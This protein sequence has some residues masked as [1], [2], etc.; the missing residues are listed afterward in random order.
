MNIA[1]LDGVNSVQSTAQAQMRAMMSRGYSEQV[2]NSID[3]ISAGY[4]FANIKG[5]GGIEDQEAIY[6]YLVRIKSVVEASPSVAYGYQDPKQLLK[7]LQF[8]INNWDTANR[9]NAIEQMAQEEERL[10]A[11]GAISVETDKELFTPSDD[12]NFDKDELIKKNGQYYRN[13]LKRGFFNQLKKITGGAVLAPV[14]RKAVAA[15]PYFAKDKQRLRQAVAKARKMTV[16]LTPEGGV[17]A[18]TRIAPN[19]LFGLNGVDDDIEK[20]LTGYDLQNFGATGSK[21]QDLEALRQYYKRQYRILSARPAEYFEN[22][23][24]RDTE[25]AK[26]EYMLTNLNDVSRLNQVAGLLAGEGM[27]EADY[28]ELEETLRDSRRQRMTRDFYHR[29]G[30]LASGENV[31]KRLITSVQPYVLSREQNLGATKLSVSNFNYAAIAKGTDLDVSTLSGIGN[32]NAV[33]NYLGRIITEINENPDEYFDYQTDYDNAIGALMYAYSN[34]GNREVYRNLAGVGMS[35]REY[36][37]FLDALGALGAKKTKEQKAEEKAAKKIAKAEKKAAKKQAKAEKKIEKQ[38]E[39][40]AKKIAK[41]EAK[42]EKKQAKAEKKIEKLQQKAANAKNEKQTAK[43]QTKIQNQQDKITAAQAKKDEKIQTIKENTADNIAWQQDK[44]ATAQKD[45]DRKINRANEVKD[46][47]IRKANAT[48]KEEKK[49]IQKEAKQKYYAYQKEVAKATGE[50]IKKTFKRVVKY[51]KKV[52]KLIIKYNPICLLIRGGLLMCLSLNL[53]RLAAKLYPGTLTQVEAAKLGVDAEMYT[54][55]VKGWQNAVKIYTNLGGTEPTLKLY[56]QKGANKHW[57]GDD[58]YS[59]LRLTEAAT[60]NQAVLTDLVDKE[61]AALKK[62]GATPTDDPNVTYHVSKQTVE[63]ETTANDPN[64]YKKEVEIEVEEPTSPTAVATNKIA[65][66]A[67]KAA[68]SATASKLITAVNNKVITTPKVT[69][70]AAK[71]TTTPKVTTAVNKVTTTPKVTTAAAKVT[72]TPKVTT[73]AAKVTTTPKVTTAVNKVTTTPKV[74]TAVNK[75][76]TTPKVTTTAAKVTTTP[77]VTTA[78]NKVTTTPKV[79]TAAAKVTTTPK[80]TT[81]V[82]KVTTTPKVTTTAAK[83]TTTPKVTTAVNKVT[84]TPKVTTT[85]AK[86]TTTPKVTTKAK[87][88]VSVVKRALKGL[89]VNGYLNGGLGEPVTIAASVTAAGTV[90]AAIIAF[91]N[92]IGVNGAWLKKAGKKVEDFVEKKQFE[93]NMTEEEKAVYED[94]SKEEKKAYREMTD[95]ERERFNVV[96]EEEKSQIMEEVQARVAEE[97]A[98]LEEQWEQEAEEAKAKKLKEDADYK[99]TTVRTSQVKVD[100]STIKLKDEG[101]TTKKVMTAGGLLIAAGAIIWWFN[102]NNLAPEK[103]ISQSQIQ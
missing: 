77:K 30:L 50:K 67:N 9:E 26:I 31:D 69:T 19:V 85:A 45:A 12:E 18:R 11:N 33:K 64:A 59:E 35:N 99:K 91:L 27:D 38:Q 10:I 53:F 20:V 23:E 7:M 47:E 42:A 40:E 97:E 41:A 32:V 88:A 82:N 46:L 51:F 15:N 100:T 55:C 60:N 65:T 56:L 96:D 48:T 81:T 93:K 101:L 79:T 4:D 74:T 1:F 22:D 84:A 68:A 25:L 86:V 54:K 24:E 62:A 44:I 58:E 28:E 17:I 29:L 92:K 57:E 13:P 89:E 70:T 8:V 34:V 98:E 73:T 76:T 103:V 90:I 43:I 78:V 102:R 16:A 52:V 39:K 66:S 3:N 37:G 87:A 49:A 80:V 63:V 2:A 6:N 14:V 61:T 83:V 5:D 71:V 36:E 75:V 95:D 21:E 72:T 94:L